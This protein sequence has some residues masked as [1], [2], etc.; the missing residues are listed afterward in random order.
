LKKLALALTALALVAAAPSTAS[1]NPVDVTVMT[2]NLFLGADLIPL[3]VADPGDPFEQAVA[4][5]FQEAQSSNF[6]ARMR[7][8]AREIAKA[9]PDVV[10][11]QEVTSWWTGPKNDPAPAG[12]LEFEHLRPLLAELKR[13]HA[14]YRLARGGGGTDLEGPSASGVD[15]RFKEDESPLLV[16]KGVRI[17]KRRA[18]AFKRLLQIPTKAL[19]TVTVTLSWAALDLVKQR[20]RFRVVNAHLE[21]YS[22]DVRLRQAKELVA[23]PLR[24]RT[25]VILVGDLNSGPKLDNPD[26][27]PPYNAI[28]GAGFT[29]R[30][31][32]RFSCCFDDLT[33]A[34]KW[35]HNVD[36]IMAKPSKRVKL[37]R[38]FV[39]GA[40]KL[41]E[42]L[43][44]SDHGGVVSTLRLR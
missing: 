8:V 3:A 15:V 19:G 14:P 30:R 43:L 4:K 32:A 18:H 33:G 23:G 13:L 41:P 39:T 27:R 37:V 17:A 5:T 6:A 7:G 10:G 35:D 36:W 9:K 40:T 44:A 34:G 20:K 24:S 42:G 16:R 25:P 11:L 29:P 1:A 21:A 28:A 31:T 12:K 38:S 22:T 26:D 2:R